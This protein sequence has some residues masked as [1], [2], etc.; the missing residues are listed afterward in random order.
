MQYSITPLC[1]VHEFDANGHLKRKKYDSVQLDYQNFVL[2]LGSL[3]TNPIL[4]D[5][6]IFNSNF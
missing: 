6:F 5:I 4:I 2:F 1:R 3:K